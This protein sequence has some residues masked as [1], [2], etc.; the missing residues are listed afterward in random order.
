V[1]TQWFMEFLHVLAVSLSTWMHSF[2]PSPPAFFADMI[3]GFNTAY[4]MVPGALKYF[5]PLAPLI[6]AGTALVA[7][8]IVLGFIRFARRV[9]SLFTGGGGNA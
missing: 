8:L 2:V 5:L 9:L 7:L 6:V 4:A 1:I 3:S